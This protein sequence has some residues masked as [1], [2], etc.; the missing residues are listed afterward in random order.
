MYLGFKIYIYKICNFNIV[1]HLIKLDYGLSLTHIKI[2]KCHGPLVTH[3]RW[4]KSWV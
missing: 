3:A 4:G 2:E 1:A